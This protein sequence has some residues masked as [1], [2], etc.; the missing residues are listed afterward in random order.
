QATVTF[1]CSRGTTYG[2]PFTLTNPTRVCFDIKGTPAKELPPQVQ[3]K[4]GPVREILIQG[5]EGGD[6]AVV[7]YMR[8]AVN[9]SRLV[10]SGNNVVLEVTG[11]VPEKEVAAAPSSPG[12]A[13]DPDL[14][15][16][17]DVAVTQRR[18]NRTRLSVKTDR[19]VTY[20][21]KLDGNTLLIDLKNG[22]IKPELMKKLDSEHAEGAVSRVK[23]FYSALD[24]H[25]SLRITLRTLIPYHIAQEGEALNIDFDPLPVEVARVS[26]TPAVKAPP[27]EPPK[28]VAVKEKA[29]PRQKAPVY[30]PA[31]TDKGKPEKT[32]S[33]RAGLFEAT[34]KQYAG[35]SMSFDFVDT[36]IRNILKLI[37]EVAGINIVWGS[38]VE[39][40]IS[41][42]L[43]NIPWDQALEMILRPNGL[44]Y[45]IEDDVLW[46]VPKAKLRDMEIS[47]G[48]RKGAMMAAKRLQGVFEAK[49]IEFI[50]IR[51]RKASDI[52]RMLVGDKT[53]TPPLPPA[54]DIEAAESK[55]SEEGEQEKGKEVKIATM[56]LYLSFDA[57]TNVI[58]ANGVRAKVDKVKELI[59]KLDVP[60]K[61]VMIEA[62]VVEATTD[63][64]RDLGIQ[65]QSLDGK[66]PGFKREWYN[67]GANFGGLTQFSTNA[68]STWVPN[69]GLAFGWLTDGGLGSIA[70]DASLALAES[71]GKA[72]IISAPK[73]LTVNGG[74][75]IISRGEVAYK[76]IAT[77]T[78]R[79]VREMKAALSLSVKPTISADNSHVTMRVKVTDD[80]LIE[81]PQSP[82]NPFPGKRE[83]TI[84]TTLM[85][86]TGETI[87]IGG[88]Y[89]KTESVTD[90]GVPWLKDIPILGWLFKVEEKTLKKFELL[91]FLTPTVVDTTKRA[92]S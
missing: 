86:R 75:A 8:Y 85:V 4:E 68:P 51:H 83:K 25:V 31:E 62:R 13:T 28:P 60:E 38:D 1:V 69:I 15:Q 47:E 32:R 43:D 55:E 10:S 50:T 90:S 9:Q 18:G 82:D 74:E 2:K 56:D 65:W 91:I 3:L 6:A 26:E 23:A 40:K 59:A 30:R 49:I 66:N 22:T 11:T 37:A 64:N 52:F 36:D 41:M 79:E 48:K 46:V 20:D 19:K 70:L 21:V 87:V 39:G 5:R 72:H 16:I 92:E 71:D 80:S 73:V 27:K 67:T 63:F 17:L 29:E 53:A 76:E 34:S 84:E 58:I 45:Q 12:V 88:I 33:D 54:L 35:Q 44:T 7:A 24:R 81:N 89:H 42:K 14:P 57:G 78:E 77:L 61:Q